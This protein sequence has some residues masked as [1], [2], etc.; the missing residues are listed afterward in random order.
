MRFK[1]GKSSYPV[2]TDWISPYIAGAVID[3]V[4]SGKHAAVSGNHGTTGGGGHATANTKS[5]VIK[6]DGEIVGNNLNRV[7]KQIELVVINEVTLKE[8]I[9]LSTGVRNGI[10]FEE[11]VTYVF[12]HNHMRIKD[13][14]IKAL[15]PMYIYWYMGLQFTPEYNNNI[16]FTFD[17]VKTGVYP[18]DYTVRNSG[19]KSESPDMTR[20]T[21]MNNANDMLHIYVDKEYGIGYDHISSDDVI[22]YG[23]E[24]NLKLYY[25][26]VKPGNV[27]E[28]NNGDSN[29]YRGGYI[30]SYN[31]GKNSNVS[32]FIED[33]IEKAFIDFRSIATETIEYQ[34]IEE[35]KNVTGN[36]SEITSTSNNAYAKVIL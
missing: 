32:K 28:F 26:L 15:T 29:S 8:N 17:N 19:T 3:G 14:S 20:A 11:H 10:D 22:A 27:L 13:V 5:A 1:N 16:Y 23:R 18:N 9:N 25:H 21:L 4:Q 2:T 33:G 24:S 6:V 36:G 30:F 34:S 7:A 12:E 31:T 35:S